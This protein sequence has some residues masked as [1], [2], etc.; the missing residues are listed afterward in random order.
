MSVPVIHEAQTSSLDEQMAVRVAWLYFVEGWTQGE[1]A[2]ALD[3][4]R[5]RINRMIN[6]ARK[7][8]LVTFTLNSRLTS[9]IELERQL[10]AAFGLKS[11]IVVPTPRD[12]D[13]LRPAIGQATA[14]YMSGVL[15]AETI[16][17]IAV[18][19]GTTIREVI[20][21]LPM[22]QRPDLLVTSALGGLTRGLEINSFDIAANMARQLGAQCGYMAAP[23]YVSSAE[24]RKI[25][26]SQ[27]VFREAFDRV[28]ACQMMLASVGDISGFSQLTRYGLPADVSLEDLREAGACGDILGHVIGCNGHPIDHPVNKRC[29][30]IDLN[31]LKKIRHVICASGGPGKAE[32]LAG[33]MLAG[34]V[35][36]VVTDEDTARAALLHG[37]SAQ[38]AAKASAH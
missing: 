31:E 3:T 33:V 36:V 5:L 21:H 25:L 6:D 2:K 18:S 32:P 8:G 19:W 10:I 16:T 28:S 38:A 27:D 9:C 22:M 37:A 17:G 24:S 12:S 29:I 13:L 11:A 7:S 23:I 14:A 30:S 4:N 34:W 1:I 35:N 20:R 26:M 15:N